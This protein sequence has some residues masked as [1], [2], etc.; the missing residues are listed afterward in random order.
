MEY[1]IKEAPVRWG[2]GFGKTG[3]LI[4][5]SNSLST[6]MIITI[7]IHNYSKN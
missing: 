4:Q 7:T 2:G 1:L 3:I 5:L 6:K